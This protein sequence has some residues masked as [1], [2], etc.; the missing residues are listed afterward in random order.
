MLKH[1][2]ITSFLLSGCSAKNK[3]ENEIAVITQAVTIDHDSFKSTKQP[4]EPKQSK[5]KKSK[6]KK[7]TSRKLV[8]LDV[9]DLIPFEEVLAGYGIKK[10]KYKGSIQGDVFDRLIIK[11]PVG[12]S[13]S[14]LKTAAGGLKRD[15]GQSVA[16]A[17]FV[18]GHPQCMA[19]DTKSKNPNIILNSD[20]LNRIADG[21]LAPL[22]FGRDVLGNVI[23]KDLVDLV[24]VKVVGASRSGKTSLL[25]SWI[26]SLMTKSTD[27][28]KLVLTDLK[29]L[30]LPLYE[31]QPHVIGKVAT[32]TKSALVNIDFLL[33][34][35][36]SRMKLL[37]GAKCKNIHEYYKKTGNELPIIVHVGDEMA[38]IFTDD[39]DNL[40]TG[41]D[42][43]LTNRKVFRDKYKELIAT[44]AAFGVHLILATQRASLDSIPS[45]VQANILE[46]V[47]LMTAS[48]SDSND[49]IGIPD[50]K[51]LF[52]KGDAFYYN[53]KIGGYE[54]I[55]TPLAKIYENA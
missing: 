25:H 33:N 28:I 44:G 45:D 22:T 53:E 24:H 10:I 30:D 23:V 46:T 37:S 7:S 6:P 4:N 15:F 27:E 31:G 55:H 21:N 19:I 5:P 48:E 13:L 2:P 17:E 51:Y 26:E 41:K 34:E 1:M 18:E 12:A 32:D 35:I 8:K 47:C 43:K 50:A 29:R 11:L 49:A 54:R 20:C 3:N 14:R 9:N 42:S 39:K 40:L 36:K 52:G 38:L 16:I